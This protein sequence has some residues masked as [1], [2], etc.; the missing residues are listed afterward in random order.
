MIDI[1]FKIIICGGPVEKYISE[2]INSVIKQ[3]YENWEIVVI[4]DK[5]DNSYEIAKAYKN[6]RIKVISN[7]IPNL[8]MKNIIEGI[9][10]SNPE[11][12]DVIVLLDGDDRLLENSLKILKK[13]YDDS[14]CWAT[15]GSMKTFSNKIFSTKYE[16]NDI[17][18]CV[19]NGVHPKT[20]KYKIWKFIDEYHF[21]YKDGRYLETTSDMAILFS[22]AE[23]AY[24]KVEYIDEII[25]D[26]NDSNPNNIFK[27]K[28]K[29]QLEDENII[30]NK[31]NNIIS[32]CVGL[33]N[34]T[35]MIMKLID[36]M[37]YCFDKEKL[38]L[39]IYDCGTEDIDIK[40]KIK[41]KWKGKLIF[42]QEKIKFSRS[43]S[44]N[45]AC[46]Q[47]K[48]RYLFMCDIDM[49][50]P[51]D[52]VRQY[53]NNV[54]Y[55]SVW[56]PT[57]FKLFENKQKFINEDNGIWLEDGHGIVGMTSNNFFD[58]CHLNEDFT[59]HGGEDNDLYYR[60][61]KKRKLKIIREKYIG[62]FHNW[63]EDLR[64][65]N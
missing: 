8:L 28:R 40:D 54:N 65:Y 57:C 34:R 24:H 42:T 23:I 31:E 33:K 19:W 56:F 41:D 49:H 46:K 14:D 43:Y 16:L 51:K 62:L 18:K 61:L 25:Y 55:K 63:H 27:N 30:R 60:I 3:S 32:I 59:E 39:S 38:K 5:F 2:C 47:A 9:K 26:Y 48:T 58:K 15:Y 35:E 6:N 21:K 12:E 1:K 36:S 37:N 50:L 45:M 29:Q 22:L 64:E 44:V 7:K 20:F 11:N 52:F 13:K 4:L 53:Y 10:I 17:R